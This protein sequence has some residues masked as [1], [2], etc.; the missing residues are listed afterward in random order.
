MPAAVSDEEAL[1]F[2]SPD[3]RRLIATEAASD[4]SFAKKISSM[5]AKPDGEKQVVMY[6]RRA[7]INELNPSLYQE[8]VGQWPKLRSAVSKL[9]I[10][11]PKAITSNIDQLPMDKRAQA[12]E[13]LS[14]MGSSPSSI[15][16]G[17]LGQFDII[18]SLIGTLASATASVYSASIVSSTQK[19]I[20]ADQL[21]ANEQEIQAQEA[22]ANAQ[23]AVA[24]AQAAQ[25]VQATLPAP[26]AGA[27]QQ[28]I[29]ALPTSLQAPVA[30]IVS[31]LST[32]MGGGIPLWLVGVGV[33]LFAKN[34]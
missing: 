32:D 20:A 27:V 23:T 29:E 4:P 6:A 28:V 13:A 33:Y 10:E 12:I 8:T 26:A 18:A 21:A 30:N 2:D 9:M 25:A 34:R 17:D 5:L 7:I 16:I 31:M 24:K 19:Q 1:V 11:L 22:A 3:D 15:G 14:S